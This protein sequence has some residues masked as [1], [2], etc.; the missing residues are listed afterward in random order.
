MQTKIAQVQTFL[1]TL[2][3]DTAREQAL[4]AGISGPQAADVFLVTG[5]RQAGIHGLLPMQ[6]QLF[7]P[8]DDIGFPLTVEYA[9]TFS[10][11]VTN[12]KDQNE[13]YHSVG[14]FRH[15]CGSR[16]RKVRH[17][18]V[19]L[20]NELLRGIRMEYLLLEDDLQQ[21][22][23]YAVHA[24][25]CVLVIAADA[26]GLSEPYLDLCRW[27]VEDRC[28]AKRVSLLLNNSS[29]FDNPMLPY[30]AEAALNRKKLGVVT[31]GA[32]ALTPQAALQAAV[33]DLQERTMEG[34]CEGT[35]LSCC[36]SVEGKLEAALAQARAVEESSRILAEKYQSAVRTYQ[37]MCVTEK[38]AFSE[39]LTKEEQE[40]LQREIRQMFAHLRASFPKMVE[41]VLAKSKHPKQD[42][43]NLS[44]DYL[45]A[46]IDAYMDALLNEI[47]DDTLI[48]RIY[49]NYKALCDRFRRMMQDSDLEYTEI[50]EKSKA[51]FL[52]MGDVNI[53]DY[54]T[55]IA[56][57]TASVLTA[58]VK[59]V[60]SAV[61]KELGYHIGRGIGGMINSALVTLTDSL[62]SSRQYAKSINK[63]VL[64]Q[65]E[66]L[67]Q[68][69]LQQISQTILPRMNSVLL[70]EF[71]KLAKVNS[72]QLLAKQKDNET[73]QS[74][75]RAQAGAL[76]EDLARLQGFR[77]A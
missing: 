41:E 71:E 22:T 12:D 47:L 34:V 60:L 45:G 42:L 33:L 75:A 46:L 67:E 37:A 15:F 69:I 30:M 64:V 72:D 28:I 39:I 26:G 17:C 49:E 11:R 50:E 54:H 2:S 44:G 59:L 16:F 66:D 5:D 68:R 76:A 10:I 9:Q 43:K 29:G 19:G 8:E 23:G 58:I 20:P 70:T 36:N 63:A 40:I 7:L 52:K 77:Q 57:L 65:L 27:L 6:E 62:M 48:P 14:D 1:Q 32:E 73:R 61:L 24:T 3:I 4:L 74:E 38:Y 51:V 13:Y 55:P 35:L 56:Q 25:G 18:L 53:G 31:C 21:V